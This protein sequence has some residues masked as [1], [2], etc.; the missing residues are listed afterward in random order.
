[1]ASVYDTRYKQWA[2]IEFLL[3]EKESV[4]N[5]HKRLCVVYESCA[6]DRSTVERWIQRVKASGSGEHD[7][8]SE[9]MATWTGNELV[10][11]GTH[12]LVSRLRKAVDVDGDYV[13]K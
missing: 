11:K 5:I 10:K 2:V 7:S 1:M 4:G 13:E 9:D 12:A 8:C 3:A 6:V